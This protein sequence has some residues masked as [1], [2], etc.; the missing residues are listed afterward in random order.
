MVKTDS[1]VKAFKKCGISNAMDGTE[2]DFL[3]QSDV[4][5]S[6]S[7]AMNNA[8]LQTFESEK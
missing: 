6:D 8:G 7:K 1:A 4:S 2:D 3:W 5:G